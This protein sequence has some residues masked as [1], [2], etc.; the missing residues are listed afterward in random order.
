MKKSWQWIIEY[1]RIA[2]NDYERKK[3]QETE[4]FLA[5]H[6]EWDTMVR[7][8][9]ADSTP[10]EWYGRDLVRWTPIPERYCGRHAFGKRD[11]PMTP[12]HFQVAQ[13]ILLR[14]V[15][16]EAL[17]KDWN[18]DKVLDPSKYV[19][20]LLNVK[21]KETVPGEIYVL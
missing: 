12:K 7:P 11:E 21:T 15:Y 3:A 13:E 4:K 19:T 10:M 2:K 6:P 20:R 8:S 9:E 18:V 14:L 16:K 17:V 1:K 5:E